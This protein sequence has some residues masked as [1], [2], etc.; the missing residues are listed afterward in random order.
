MEKTTV[1]NKAYGPG[2]VG[3]LGGWTDDQIIKDLFAI[4]RPDIDTSNVTS[5]LG[6]VMPTISF[7]THTLEQF[8][9]RVLKI[10]QGWFRIDYYKRLF[11][12]G[13]GSGPGSYAPFALSDTPNSAVPTN[14]LPSGDFESGTENWGTY[15]GRGANPTTTTAQA[16]SG[17]RSL[18]M[19]GN[20]TSST[21]WMAVYSTQVSGAP[22]AYVVPGGVGTVAVTP[23][24][25]YSGQLKVRSAVTPRPFLLGIL[26]HDATGALLSGGLGTSTNSTTSGWTQLA[27]G[28]QTAPAN[29][30][31]AYLGVV[32]S[33]TGVGNPD[34]PIPQGEVH[35]FD[36]AGIFAGAAPAW[37][38]GGVPTYGF[39]EAHTPPT[40]PPSST[41]SGS[42][43]ASRRASRRRIH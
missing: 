1:V 37:S 8:F 32:T 2:D 15:F 3:H 42:S 40:S 25:T 18:M 30:A 34:T 22:T 11:Y 16:A 7:P 12:G 38:A 21:T 39:E 23:G 5:A 17:T 24:S 6:S 26:W 33:T 36:Q 4:Y 31:W 13:V 43:A 29:A 19:V 41:G 28:T 35:Y 14:R 9:Q 20:G 27:T 10:S